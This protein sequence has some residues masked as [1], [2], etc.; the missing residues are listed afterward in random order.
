VHLSAADHYSGWVGPPSQGWLTF[1]YASGRP[2][3]NNGLTTLVVRTLYNKTT[4][5]QTGA[6]ECLV[7]GG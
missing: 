7:H 1:F 2:D 4:R 6:L 5:H 3:R